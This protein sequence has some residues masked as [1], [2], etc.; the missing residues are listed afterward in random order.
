MK[1]AENLIDAAIIGAQKAGTTSLLHWLGQHPGV[2][3]QQTMEFSYFI[4]RERFEQKTF[5]QFFQKN[6]APAKTSGP[7]TLIKHVGLFDNEAALRLFR[8]HNPAARLIVV[9]RE[10]AERAWSAFWYARSRGYEPETDFLRAAFGRPRD[11]FSDP[12]RQR[13][14]DYVARGFYFDHLQVLEKIFPREQICLVAFEDLKK[15]PQRICDEVFRF[16]GLAPHPVVS[17]AENKTSLP[18]FHGL[19]RALFLL[20]PLKR[21]LPESWRK[22]LKIRLK[23]LNRSAK[24]T[25]AMPDEIRRRLE[26][27]FREKNQQLYAEYG[28]DYRARRGR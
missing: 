17:S 24:P 20:K 15:D 11:Y 13:S 12:F 1:T 18:R 4:D 23:R 5:E 6:F 8:E 25:P 16:L 2:R 21:F 14:T 19:S 10:P 9:L 27:I 22:F 7:L 28:I 3:A 26:D